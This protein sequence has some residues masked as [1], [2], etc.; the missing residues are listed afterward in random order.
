MTNLTV[1]KTSD[2]LAAIERAKAQDEDWQ[3]ELCEIAMLPAVEAAWR[4]ANKGRAVSIRRIDGIPHKGFVREANLARGAAEAWGEVSGYVFDYGIENLSWNSVRSGYYSHS[5]ATTWD[6]VRRETYHEFIEQAR[7]AV[8]PVKV[9]AG[10][11]HTAFDEHRQNLAEYGL[12][13]VDDAG[14]DKEA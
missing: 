4:K 14:I 9:R 11:R 8:Y 3:A 1:L 2:I 13:L 6:G 12:E 5:A 7:Y 10:F